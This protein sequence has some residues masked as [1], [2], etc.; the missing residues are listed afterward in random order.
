MP[1]VLSYINENND[2][3]YILTKNVSLFSPEFGARFDTEKVAAATANRY[4]KAGVY[5]NIKIELYT[6]DIIWE[7]QYRYTFHSDFGLY[8]DNYRKR[9]KD[10]YES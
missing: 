10:P 8:P 9:K 2:K 1:Y 5:N 6:Y 7:A 3:K 4:M